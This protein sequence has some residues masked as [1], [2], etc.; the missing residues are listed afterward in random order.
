M[1]RISGESV[2][3]EMGTEQIGQLFSSSFAAHLYARK[4][5]QIVEYFFTLICKKAVAVA[6]VKGGRLLYL[7]LNTKQRCS[8]S[9]SKNMSFP[10]S[11]QALLS[12]HV[13][14]VVDTVVN[15]NGLRIGQRVSTVTPICPSMELVT[16]GWCV[17]F[18]RTGLSGLLKSISLYMWYQEAQTRVLELSKRG[19]GYLS[20]VW[21]TKLRDAGFAQQ[22]G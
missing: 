11:F 19:K 5:L 16:K 1:Y 20:L 14:V 17:L 15:N 22:A 21:K 4:D 13:T 18:E 12:C 8:F 10:I 3:A 7:V 2:L 9:P 6:L